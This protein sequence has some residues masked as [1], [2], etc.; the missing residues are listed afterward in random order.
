M[1]EG[2]FSDDEQWDRVKAWWK[3][4]GTFIITG[5]VVGLLIIGGWRYWEHYQARQQLTASALYSKFEQALR[6]PD[7][8]DTGASVVAENLMD[9]YSDTPYAAQAALALAATEVSA[10]NLEQAADHLQWVIDNGSDSSL[11]RLARLRLGRIQLASG[12][13][14]AAIKTLAGAKAG[15]FESLYAEARGDAWRTLGDSAKA[16]EAYQAALTA[17]T[18]EMGDTTLLEMKLRQTAAAAGREASSQS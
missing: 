11:K 8:A 7:N 10:S 4:N 6:Q 14:K 2:N 1:A 17:H 18:G 13:P 3:A 15:G 5:L 16:H 9:H 12:K